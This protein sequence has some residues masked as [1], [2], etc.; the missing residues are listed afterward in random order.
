MTLPVLVIGEALIDVV[1][2]QDGPVVAYP[3]GS[4]ANVAITL[5]RLGHT[6]RLFAWFGLDAHGQILADHLH[7]SGVELVP[8]SQDA[9]RTSTALARLDD[10]GAAEY[11]FEIEW[12]LPHTKVEEEIA[13][14]HIGSIAAVLEP[15]ATA[16]AEIVRAKREDAIITYDPNMRPLLM[17]QPEDVRGRVEELVA[18][19]DVVKVSDE[20]L[21][22]LYPHESVDAVA[23][24][25]QA[26][27]PAV[28]VIT[29]GGTGATAIT[30]TEHVDVSAPEVV[31]AD[32]VG[33]GDSFMGALIDYL[34]R[35][36][37]LARG[38][39]GKLGANGAELSTGGGELGA[40][41]GELDA[42]GGELWATRKAL[43]AMDAATVRELLEHAAGV[44]AITVSRPGANP[45]WLHELSL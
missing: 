12:K 11:E 38:R 24:R 2:P 20:D 35:R 17:G 30:A 15:G 21:E 25:W 6:A 14:L 5:A 27:G 43:R 13:A 3:G 9:P 32:T 37:L 34:A 10:T 45:P 33:A 1:H 31:V 29:R 8:G 40:D 4:P 42:D 7:Q 44:A 41:G 19:S 16:V 18:L 39:R 28:I 22:W 23:R 26:L 36:G